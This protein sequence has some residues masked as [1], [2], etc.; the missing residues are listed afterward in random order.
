[1]KKAVA[2]KWSHAELLDRYRRLP[3]GETLREAAG[4]I[5][6][7]EPALADRLRE[8]AREYKMPTAG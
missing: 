4:A 3:D 7:R 5:E 2:P 1:M 8:I 6:G